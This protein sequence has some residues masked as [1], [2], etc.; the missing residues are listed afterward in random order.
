MQQEALAALRSDPPGGGAEED[1]LVL[2]G[3]DLLRERPH[4]IPETLDLRLVHAF[5][6][7]LQLS[8]GGGVPEEQ[9]A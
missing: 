8:G 3:L 6:E 4:E 9:K 1:E 5:L 7:I 2:Q